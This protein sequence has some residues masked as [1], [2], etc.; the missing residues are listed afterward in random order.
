[1]KVRLSLCFVCFYLACFLIASSASLA[2]ASRSANETSSGKVAASGKMSLSDVSAEV[3]AAP[4]RAM[5]TF[6]A[7][8]VPHDYVAFGDVR[9]Y[10]HILRKKVVGFVHVWSSFHLGASIKEVAADDVDGD[11]VMDLVVVTSAGRMFIFDTD[12]RQLVWEN[13]ANDFKRVSSILI[14]QLDN[15]KAKELILCADSRLVIMDG[16][17][18]IREYQSPDEFKAEY[19]AI[20]D[21]DDDDEKEIVLDSGFVVNASTLNIEWQTDFFGTRLTLIDVDGDG[22]SE[23]VCESSGGALRVYDLDIRQEKTVY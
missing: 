13:R 14:D 18:L 2:C 19:M 9:G 20:G 23:L 1:M 8:S 6:Q 4:F 22:V 11:G 17:K 15:D 16:E 10:M 3:V 12:T 5:A 21:I 7:D